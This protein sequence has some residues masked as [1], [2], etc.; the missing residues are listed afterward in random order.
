MAAFTDEGITGRRAALANDELTQGVLHVL[1]A[2]YVGQNPLIDDLV[3]ARGNRI[4]RCLSQKFQ[5][6][7]LVSPT[8]LV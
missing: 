1:Q 8:V 7:A 2:L 6:T 5:P 3:E 4:H